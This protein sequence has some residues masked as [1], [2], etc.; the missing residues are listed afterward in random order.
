MWVVKM[1]GAFQA[2]FAGESAARAFRAERALLFPER[3]ITVGYLHADSALIDMV[4]SW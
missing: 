2:L 3:E 4:N 1:D